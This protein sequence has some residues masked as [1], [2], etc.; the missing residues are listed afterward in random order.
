MSGKMMSWAWTQKLDDTTRLVLLYLAHCHNDK[1]GQCNPKLS[2]ISDALGKSERHIR[3]AVTKLEEMGLISRELRHTKQGGQAANNYALAG[4]QKRVGP[5]HSYV[6]GEGDIAM[7]Y[8]PGHTV[9]ALNEQELEQPT[10]PSTDRAVREMRAG[11]G[12]KTANGHAWK[13]NGKAYH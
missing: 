7:S 9:S 11:A 4:G 13:P 12:G 5:G 2:T 3:R 10:V 8:P 1:T 6:R